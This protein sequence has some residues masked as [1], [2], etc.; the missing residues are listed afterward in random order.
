MLLFIKH[1][2][3]RVIE[4]W[5]FSWSFL[6]Y[7]L[8]LVL[9]LGIGIVKMLEAN[10]IGYCKCLFTLLLILRYGGMLLFLL[11][12]ILSVFIVVLS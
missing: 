8:V 10:I 3:H 1:N 2:Q 12:P 11:I 4:F 5:D 7:T 6:C 9:V